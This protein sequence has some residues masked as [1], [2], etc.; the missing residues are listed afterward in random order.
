MDRPNPDYPV[1]V[2]GAGPAGLATAACLARR[3]IAHRLL[4]RGPSL[5]ACWRATYDSLVLHTGR[6]MSRLP[7]GDYPKGTP[8]FPTRDQF[9]AYLEQYARA[10]ALTVETGCDV[11]QLRRSPHGWAATLGTGERIEGSSAVICSGI[12]SNPRVPALPGRERFHGTVMHSVE[13]RR[14]QPFVG[15]RVL[16]VGVGNSGGEIGSE[17]ARAGAQVTMLVRTGAHVVPLSIAG[18]PIQYL[19]SVVRRFPRPVQEWVVGRVQRITEARRGAPVIPRPPHSALDAIPIVGFHLVDAIK[20]GQAQLQLGTIDHLTED[21]AVFS[22]GREGAFDAIVLATG[23]SPALGFLHDLVQ[24]D[25][26]GFARRR[27]RVTSADQPG[28]Y[29]VGHNYD[30]SGGITNIRRDAPVV[31]AHIAECRS[32]A[33]RMARDRERARATLLANAHV[34]DEIV[35]LEHPAVPGE[36]PCVTPP[37]TPLPH[38]PPRIVT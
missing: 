19:S 13:Y 26:R 8:L 5:G 10:N 30:A 27:D 18:V 6:H 35:Q 33:R 24:C 1:L 2:I 36:A 28:L 21:G 23:F 7:G 3:R 22:D 15:K 17:L 38:E 34:Q 37:D 20:A 12:M 14:P 11:V 25:D 29:F 9:V 31:A 32:I 4:E 16:V